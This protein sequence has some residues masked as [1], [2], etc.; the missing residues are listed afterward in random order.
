[1]STDDTSQHNGASADDAPAKRDHREALR[2]KAQLVHAQQRRAGVLRRVLIGVGIV[3]VLAVVGV[4]VTLAWTSANDTPQLAPTNMQQDGVVIDSVTTSA[5]TT[6][7]G[8]SEADPE[9][10][11]STSAEEAKPAPVEIRVYI[12][13]LSAQSREFQQANAAQLGEWVKQGAVSL[14]YHPVALLTAKSNGTKYSLR[15]ANAGVC[16]A[17]HSPETFFAFNHSLLTRQPEFDTDGFD[18]KTLADMAIASGAEDPK[19][20]RSCIEDGSYISWVQ[21]AT[22]RAL[23]EPLPGADGQKLTGTPTVL[24]DGKPYVG[25][26]T[27]AKEF[28]QFVLMLSS[29]AYYKAT[30]S[31]TPTPTP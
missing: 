28:A 22:A 7:E 8:A 12:D 30:P 19:Q 25:S 5:L 18:S 26:M 11:A 20:M 9:A 10:E 3:A 17:T 27:D 24:V 23:S 16:V 4:G 13:Y 6:G 15:A 29:D 1:M 14:S 21:A 31:P 2:E